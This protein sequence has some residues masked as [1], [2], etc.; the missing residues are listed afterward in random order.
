M[1]LRMNAGGTEAPK[2]KPGVNNSSEGNHHNLLRSQL[3]WD[4]ETG[5]LP[6]WEIKVKRLKALY[7]H[8]HWPL[9]SS[10]LAT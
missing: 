7:Q 6:Y 3:K 10:V 8:E 5:N 2:Q 1:P 4:A 9:L